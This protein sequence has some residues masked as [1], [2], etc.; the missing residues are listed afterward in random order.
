MQIICEDLIFGIVKDNNCEQQCQNS[1]I[2]LPLKSVGQILEAH[3]NIIA[4]RIKL[5][6]FD[7]LDSWTGHHFKDNLLER[8]MKFDAIQKLLKSVL[9]FDPSLLL[10]GLSEPPSN[11]SS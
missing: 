11:Q 6:C 8:L 9:E 1:F 5:K 4:Q 2:V 7:L 10:L 3:H